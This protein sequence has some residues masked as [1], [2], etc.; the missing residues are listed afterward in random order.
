MTVEAGMILRLRRM[1][2]EPTDATYTDEILEALILSTACVDK[3]GN[4]PTSESWI[5]TYDLFKVASET[6]LEKASVFQQEFDFNADGGD[7]KR[8]QKYKHAI[9]QSSVFKS[10]SKALSLM[11]KQHPI[12][13]LTSLSQFEDLEY[14]DWIDDYESKLV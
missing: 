8:S 14:K 11:L 6:W 12:N 7:F 1:I 4:E 2:A 13:N 9:K 10:R 5:P 3:D